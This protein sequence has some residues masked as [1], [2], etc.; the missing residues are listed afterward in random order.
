ME[1]LIGAFFI[2]GLIWVALGV[3]VGKVHTDEA[4]GRIGAV[5][6]MLLV[7]PLIL[8]M[9]V[10]LVIRP[11]IT[12]FWSSVSAV[13][14]LAFIVVGVLAVAALATLVLKVAAPRFGALTGRF[15]RR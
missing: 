7:A 10:T 3:M 4:A 9:I 12:A 14:H 13:A 5:L 6:L 15:R 11:I 1:G 8:S 2:V